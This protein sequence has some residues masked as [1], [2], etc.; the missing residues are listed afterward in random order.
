MSR[1]HS[2]WRADDLKLSERELGT[3]AIIVLVLLFIRF[4]QGLLAFG[5]MT[6]A[7]VLLM[8]PAEIETALQDFS[9]IDRDIHEQQGIGIGLPLA[10]LI[11]QS[12]GGRLDI[13]SEKG[14]GTRVHI[15]LPYQQ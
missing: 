12:H 2:V 6:V 3:V 1:L 11:I 7:I 4:A 9:Q 5:G 10:N 15:Y 8:M 13:Q 14:K